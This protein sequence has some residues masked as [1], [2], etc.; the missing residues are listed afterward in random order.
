MRS[1]F[2]FAIACG[3]AVAQAPT[4]DAV[5]Q[6]LTQRLMALKPSSAAE[7]NVVFQ[8]LRPGH[9][10]GGTFKFRATVLVRDYDRGYPANRYYGRTC[11]GKLDGEFTMSPNGAGGW[12]V[13]GAITPSMDQTTCQPNPSDGVSSIPLST[14]Q[15]TVAKAGA[16]P[17]PALTAAGAVRLGSYECWA[18][19]EARMLMNFRIASTTQYVDS[20]GKSGTYAVNGGRIAFRGGLLDG[21]MPAGFYAT[22]EMVQG[23]PKVSFRNSGGSEVQYCE[24]TK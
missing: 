19:G 1:V 21:V 14:L 18:N 9:M 12:I 13:E 2:L 4:S 6:T 24:W 15:G 5:Q 7:R 8:A 16:P 20:E 22:Y 17:A 23:R 11:V 10:D 3:I